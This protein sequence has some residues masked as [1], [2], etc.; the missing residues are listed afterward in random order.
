MRA[1]Q[2]CVLT[3]TESRRIFGTGKM[4]L[5]PPVA[6]AAVRSQAVVPLLLICRLMYFP[7][8]VGCCV[9]LCLLCIT[10]CPF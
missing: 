10:L 3:T 4:H 5:S 1:K 6:W 7:F 8:D 9:C 2:F